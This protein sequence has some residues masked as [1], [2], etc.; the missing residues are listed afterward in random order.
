ME[1]KVKSQRTTYT[2]TQVCVYVYIVFTHS[3]AKT[4]RFY[5]LP[6]EYYCCVCTAHDCV[7]DTM[8]PHETLVA[9]PAVSVCPDH[10]GYVARPSEQH[11]DD[12]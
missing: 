5:R 2:Y 10:S 4:C 12:R 3:S 6:I 9:M 8:P 7:A 11:R 1:K